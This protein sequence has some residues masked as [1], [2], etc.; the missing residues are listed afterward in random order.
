M[1]VPA[2][3]VTA[4]LREINGGHQ[5]SAP[6]LFNLIYHDLHRLAASYMRKERPDHTLQATALV[7]EAYL[8]LFNGEPFRWENRKQLFGSMAYIMRNLLVDHARK[9]R[10]DKRGGVHRKLSLDEALI[11]SDDHATDMLALN[12]GL[13]ELGRLNERQVRVAELRFFV[14]LTVEE[15]AAV[16]EVSPETVKLDWRLA[17]AFLSQRLGSATI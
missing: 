1:D 10:A 16:L 3:D 6:E 14:G 2:G 17:K 5:V 11:A 4:L 9:H 12:E 8:R 7:H 13:E 15:T